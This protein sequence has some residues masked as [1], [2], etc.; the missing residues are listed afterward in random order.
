MKHARKLTS[1]LLA[2]VMVFA[3]AVTV[4][5]EG[6]TATTTTGK[7]TVDNP[8]EGQN[9]TAYKIFDV[10]Y[11]A[12]KKNYSYTIKDTSEWYN[13]VSAYTTGLTLNK[14]G[15]TT[16]NTYV[17]TTTDAFSPAAFADALKKAL[18]ADS[19]AFNGTS[20]T[21]NG[22]QATATVNEL[23]YYFVTSTNGALCNLTTTNP[24][25]TIYDKNN[26]PFEKKKTVEKNDFK[27]GDTVTFNI[28]GK[29]PD[30]TG[31][32]TYTYL[33]TDTMSKGLTFDE[34]SVQVKVGDDVLTA[35]NTT[36]TLATGGAAD[37]YTFKV[38]IYVKNYA[39]GLPIEVAYTATINENAVA[40]ISTNKAELIYSN[41]P[42]D[43]S[44]TGKIPSEE[45]KVYSSKIA[46]EKVEK[47]ADGATA[48]PKKLD[49]AEFVLYKEEKTA[50]AKEATKLYYKWNDTAKKV[51]WVPNKDQATVKETGKDGNPG[52]ASFDGLANGT[53]YLVETKAP[54]GY[55]QLT[56]P[57]EVPVNGG[58]TETA[59]T[60]TERVENQA[61]AVLPSTGGMGT[62]IFYVLGAVLVVGAGVLLVTKKR[63]SQSDI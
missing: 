3:L 26:V 58:T 52:A 53:Y 6:D 45:V 14:V 40:K 4:A 25:V 55:N 43:E 59:L 11:D 47:L 36:Y 16:S 8:I 42:T 31:F 1:L 61:G 24:E 29:V 63:M 20:L 13:T 44:Q 15:D 39:V 50:G 28:T 57:V 10:V 62:T 19:T 17:V 33:I 30:H 7:I 49:G 54:A 12:D 51:E 5:A 41:D 22:T 18:D 27:V 37:N 32:K 60:V 9:Y 35:G 2:L 23:G 48:T 38:T 34:N 21:R 56:G 46:I